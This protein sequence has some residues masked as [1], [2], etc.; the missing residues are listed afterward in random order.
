MIPFFD[1]ILLISLKGFLSNL[2]NSKMIFLIS[3]KYLNNSGQ[4]S[5]VGGPI[6]LNY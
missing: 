5:S 3:G 1:K 6:T 2:G 4:L